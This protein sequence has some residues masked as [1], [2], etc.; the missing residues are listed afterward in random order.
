MRSSGDRG[1]EDSLSLTRILQI[2]FYPKVLP[3]MLS[4]LQSF[5]VQI[6]FKIFSNL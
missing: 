3:V 6:Y 5:Q 2:M 4:R 1:Y